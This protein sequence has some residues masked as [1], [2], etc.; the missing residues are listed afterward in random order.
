[1]NTEMN[2]MLKEE[3]S[4]R[5]LGPWS[6]SRLDHWAFPMGG[7]GAGMICLEGQGS[8]SHVSLR[9][10]MERFHEP[11]AFAALSIEGRPEL[12]RLVEG[13]VPRHKIFAAQGGGL[14]CVARTYGLPRFETSTAISR[15]PFARLNLSSKGYPLSASVVGWSPFTP[16]NPDPSSL[17]VAGLEYSF[18]NDS[19]EPLSAVFSFHAAN[20]LVQ[21]PGRQII[22]DSIPG[23]HGVSRCDQGFTLWEEGGDAAARTCAFRAIVADGDVHV[24]P[25]WFRG[26]WYDAQTM[27]WH[28]VRDGIPI[29]R[30]DYDDSGPASPGASLFVP[31][32]LQPG[33]ESSVRLLFS[34]YAPFSEL[35]Y[36]ADGQDTGDT[37]GANC[38]CDEYEPGV[39]GGVS[40]HIASED[41]KASA[42]LAPAD[43]YQ[44]WYASQFDS[45]D[46]IDSYW[47]DA[48]DVLREQSVCFADTFHDTTLPQA[49]LEAVS[50][51]LSILKSPT[52]MRQYD[53]RF[54]AWEG[55]RDGAGCCFGNCTHVW[56]YAHAL[57][58]LFPKLERSMR[59]SE[60]GDCQNELGHQLYR[61]PL[62]L[63]PGVHDF[64]AVADG[65][66]G[67]IV[68]IYRDWR[69]SGDTDWLRSLWQP[70]RASLE[71]CITA[72]DSD[73]RGD[74]SEPH[75]V[76][77]DIEFWGPE[78]L[79]SSFYA[80]AL[81]SAIAMAEALGEP[82]NDYPQILNGVLKTLQDR[83]YN[84]EYYEQILEW[85]AKHRGPPED[86]VRHPKSSHYWPEALELLEQEG[87]KY[88]YGAGCLADGV[89][90]D[91]MA[92]CSGLG[93]VMNEAEVRSH[94]ASVW[95]YNFRD[96][97]NSHENPQRPGYALGHEAGLLL[98]TWPR[99]GEPTL[100]FVYS[101]E[102]W[103]GIEYQVAAHTAMLGDQETAEKIVK[104][105]R[106]RYGG[107]LRN[108]FNEYECGHFY[109]RA[110]SSWTLLQSM[111][112]VRYDAV[113]QA[114]VVDCPPPR[115]DGR[116][117]LS[118]ASGYGS[119]E[120][121]D[122]K[123]RVDVRSG[124]IPLKNKHA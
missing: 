74:L 68:K 67:G 63:R 75:H 111:S 17:P 69:I 6:D 115:P 20:F 4:G 25:R 105:V 42:P 101:N 37:S 119:V 82:I 3:W 51:N 31:L 50:A 28:G 106:S 15:F 52:V 53:G 62:P 18:R 117:F 29:D 86:L 1:M 60:F 35:N 103:T 113:D 80:A 108:P 49:M 84:G 65:Q 66:L 85:Q 21:E 46:S 19:S 22:A 102:V 70:V 64:L 9:H 40:R 56:N 79:T 118:T 43:C 81:Q 61:H 116:Y 38:S 54:W 33:E 99:G 8:L 97:L 45:I 39:R 5:V 112:G 110:L 23:N 89:I 24:N 100:P 13:A 95:K 36:G 41:V 121:K 47:R 57:A 77:Y 90:G 26:G 92:R 98:C 16:P 14:G 34:W 12:A 11:F 109:A 2:S 32:E 123:P 120:W 104:S 114:L 44:P 107:D 55:C 87:P 122:G 94:L 7:I 88:Q 91:W 27:V 76:T 93:A 73:R 30:Q 71:Y 72:W 58:H 96:D 10:R 83:L 59:E 124:A 78:S 48:Y